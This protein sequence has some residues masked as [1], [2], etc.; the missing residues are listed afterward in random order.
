MAAI[1]TGSKTIYLNDVHIP[2]E[3]ATAVSLALQIIRS[4]QPDYVHLNGDTLDCPQLSR[5]PR[6]PLTET[7]L[8]DDLDAHAEF[9]CKVRRAAPKARIVFNAGNHEHR[10]TLVM[11]NNQHLFGLED[12]RPSKVLRLEK[13]NIP[14]HPYGTK[15]DHQG[16]T[17]THGAK[18]NKHAGYA[19]KAMAEDFM[20]NIIF[21]HGHK[22]GL[23]EKR[24]F[25]H[26]ALAMEVPCLCDLSPGYVN[27]VANWSHGIGFL[28]N[29]KH[30]RYALPQLIRFDAGVALVGDKAFEA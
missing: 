8:K 21:A 7:K 13:F 22:A 5:W 20:C 15:L 18:T 4:V 12:F 14:Y 25:K 1:L 2:H 29:R 3:D 19:A 11:W 17:W 28:Y 6:D 23:H 26:S 16:W 30:Y 9:L 10:Y 27:G 24:G